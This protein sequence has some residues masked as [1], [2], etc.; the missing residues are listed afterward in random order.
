MPNVDGGLLKP[1]PNRDGLFV[2]EVVVPNAPVPEEVGGVLVP[3]PKAF[4][5]EDCCVVP[6]PDCCC[7]KADVPAPPPS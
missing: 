4:P 2:V 7:P 1:A 5:E 3:P 6:N